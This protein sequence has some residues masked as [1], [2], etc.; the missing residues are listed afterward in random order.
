MQNVNE[1]VD[2]LNEAY[3]RRLAEKPWRPVFSV[4]KGKKFD[5]VIYKEKSRE[6]MPGASVYC[7]VDAE[8]N[9][10]KADGWKRPAKGVRARLADISAEFVDQIA[11]RGYVNTFWL[12]RR[13][14]WLY[15]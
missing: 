15:R 14:W 13:S 6:N 12:Y 7:F 1:F 9:I 8:G 2:A 10:Y 3:D 11:A 5:K 4:V